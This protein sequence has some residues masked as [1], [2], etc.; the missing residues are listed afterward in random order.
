[1]YIISNIM[2]WYNIQML[3]ISLCNTIELILD[4]S[5]LTL[6]RGLKRFCSPDPLL[7]II[8]DGFHWHI[9]LKIGILCLKRER[10]QATELGFSS[11]W[12]IT[13]P[14]CPWLRLLQLRFFNWIFYPKQRWWMVRN[15]IKLQEKLQR[16]TFQLRSQD[17]VAN[18]KDVKPRRFN[19]E[20]GWWEVLWILRSFKKHI[21]I[22]IYMN[23]NAWMRT[24]SSLDQW[25]L[26]QCS[27][28]ELQKQL[29]TTWA[30]VQYIYIYI[31]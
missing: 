8:M 14:R 12:V 26:D 29:P 30:R 27:T 22:Y 6:L 3:A 11:L 23:V 4:I 5:S 1:M 24:A 31:Y 19:V 2:Q 9:C 17:D 7:P 25:L 15:L 21:Y 28:T 20:P 16:R 10:R 18:C 13:N